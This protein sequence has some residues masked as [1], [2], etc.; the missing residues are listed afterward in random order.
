M[1]A[2]AAALSAHRAPASLLAAPAA[3]AALACGPLAGAAAGRA[4]ASAAPLTF[5]SNPALGLGLYA[6]PALAVALFVETIVAAGCVRMGA[7]TLPTSLP[8]QRQHDA[9]CP[10]QTRITAYP[11]ANALTLARLPRNNAP[12]AWRRCSPAAPLRL[13]APSSWAPP[14]PGSRS[15]QPRPPRGSAV[16]TYPSRGAGSRHI[17]CPFAFLLVSERG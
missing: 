2:T 9:T 12:P 6:P 15:P 7:P 8:A 10:D 1:L 11:I 5:Y 17:S 4:V 16:G 14:S 3:L 13:S